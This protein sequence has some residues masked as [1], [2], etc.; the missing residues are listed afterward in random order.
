M[1]TVRPWE[2]LINTHEIAGAGAY[3]GLQRVDIDLGHLV[4]SS[5]EREG[6]AERSE[7]DGT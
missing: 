5:T 3:L 2:W 6:A 1:P 4:Q 7:A